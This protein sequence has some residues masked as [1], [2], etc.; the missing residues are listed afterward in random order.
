MT[1]CWCVK[2]WWHPL[3]LAQPAAATS[4]CIARVHTRTSSPYACTDLDWILSTEVGKSG[5]RNCRCDCGSVQ[6]MRR[7]CCRQRNAR[8]REVRW[9]VHRFEGGAR[10]CAWGQRPP[11]SCRPAQAQRKVETGTKD[12]HCNEPFRRPLLTT[13]SDDPFRRPLLT[14]PDDPS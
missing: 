13:P 1:N 4:Q 2:A 12:K 9:D 10:D 3:L 8:Y 7:A 11:Q 14:P 6:G 5:G